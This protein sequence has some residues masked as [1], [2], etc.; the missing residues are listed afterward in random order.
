MQYLPL[1]LTATV[2]N[3]LAA[4][5]PGPDFLMCVRNS[6]S[7]SRRA[8]VYSGVGISMGLMVH[9]F[10]CS[11]G[12]GLIIAKS[13][14]VFNIIKYLGA[15]YLIYIGVGAILS[16][17]Q[18]VSFEDKN[19][20]TDL[21]AFQAIK[22]GFL[23][24]LLN[25]KATLFFLAFF[26]MVLSPGTPAWVVLTVACIIVLTALVWFSIVATLFSNAWI[27]ERYLR[28]QRAINSLFGGLLIAIGIKIALSGR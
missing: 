24:N 5:S 4:I 7:Y 14:L 2:I 20:N 8:G 10:Y 27:R 3:L 6:V 22:T 23:T 26:P 11:V 19:N 17:K 16:K 28:F 15:A 18:Q 13:I 1:I 12:I 21:T 25:P 9:M